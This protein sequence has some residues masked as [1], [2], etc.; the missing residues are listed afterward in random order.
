KRVSQAE[1]LLRDLG[2]YQFR[3][4]SHGDLARIEVLPGEMERFFKQSFRDKITKELQKL[5]FTYITLD[6]AGYRT[7]SMNEELKEEDRTVWKN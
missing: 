1:G 2:F 4:R 6:M 5:G 7:G 3:V